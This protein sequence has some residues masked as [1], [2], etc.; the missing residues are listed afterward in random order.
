MKSIDTKLERKKVPLDLETYDVL[1]TF[2][3]YHGLK[4][5]HVIAA[6][7]DTLLSQDE[8]SAKIIELARLKT[9]DHSEQ[10]N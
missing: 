3:R 7:A 5:R 8:L 6:M 9:E 2:S 10:V 1:K 4:L